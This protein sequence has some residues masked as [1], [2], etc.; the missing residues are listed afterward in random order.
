MTEVVPNGG[1]VKKILHKSEV[2]IIFTESLMVLFV[3]EETDIS[4]SD[5]FHDAVSG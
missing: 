2:K 3:H 5:L 1:G 4:L